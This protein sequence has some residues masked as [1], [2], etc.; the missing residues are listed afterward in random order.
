MLLVRLACAWLK[1]S[2]PLN[3]RKSTNDGSE[4]GESHKGRSLLL[5]VEMFQTEVDERFFQDVGDDEPILS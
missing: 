3:E 4:Q 2:L 1:E 5:S